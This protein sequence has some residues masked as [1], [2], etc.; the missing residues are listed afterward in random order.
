MNSE[1]AS[2]MSA[3]ALGDSAPW[4]LR[5]VLRTSDF[6]LTVVHGLVW[7]KIELGIRL[8]LAQIFFVSGILKLTHWQTALNL[9]A[10]EYPV[11]WMNPVTAAYT[12]VSIEV[13]GGALLAVGFITRYAAIPM[14]ALTLVIQ[15]AYLPF[16]NQLFWTALLGWYAVHGA[17]S[18]SIDNLLRRGLRDSALPLIPSIMRATAWIRRHVTS[19]YLSALRLWLASIVLLPALSVAVNSASGNNELSRWLPLATTGN[20]QTGV[21]L[22]SGSLLLLGLG[23]R[24]LGMGLILSLSVGVMIDPR[25]TDTVYLLMLC[26]LFITYGAGTLSLDAWLSMHLKRRYPQLMQDEDQTQG[27]PRVVIVGAGFG[28][29]ACATALR[30]ASVAVTIIDR[31]NYHLFQPLLYQVATAA[32]SPGDIAAPVRPLFRGAG[33]TRVLLGT[34]TSVDTQQQQVRMG[35]K[36]IPYDY[37]VLATGAAHSYFGKDQWAPYAPGLK[38]IEDATEIRRRILTAFERAE[39][40]E[41]A[42]ERAALLTFLIVGGG[43]TGVELAGAI[44]ELARFGMDKEFRSFDP[45]EA[46]VILV[47]S[48]PRLLPAFPEKLAAIAQRSL[49]QL[50]VEVLIGSRV[51]NIDADGVTVSGKRVAAKTVLWAAGVMASPAAKWLQTPADNAGRVKVGMDLSVPGLANVYAIGDT[52]LSNAWNN[53][54]VPGLAPA[55]KQGGVYVARQLRARIEGRIDSTPFVYRHLGSLATIGRKAAVADFGFIKLWGAPAWWLWGAIHVGF[56]VGVRNRLSTMVNWFWSY[57]TFGG[58]IRL[59]TG[60]TQ[61]AEPSPDDSSLQVLPSTALLTANRQT[62]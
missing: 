53:Q 20:L 33:R 4:P 1:Q 10:E 41:N 2:A 21:A 44:V 35:D 38:R 54:P 36:Q 5:A 49:E 61:S 29:I 55:A 3:T 26:T 25:Q 17:G 45:A 6:F 28:G 30:R 8:W 31:C 47:Q 27:L 24:Y 58:G 13:L 60:D 37:L 48:A 32:L 16:D 43:P 22:V 39:A 11:S 19:W 12:G 9:A 52:A 59:I 23:T 57:L 14:L 50:G 56:L 34:V 51:E 40:C 62:A 42:Q 7:P 15:F 46:R 18:I